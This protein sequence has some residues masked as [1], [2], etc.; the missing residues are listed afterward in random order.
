MADSA[1][2]ALPP[3]RRRMPETIAD[4]LLPP[5]CHL[6]SRTGIAESQALGPDLFSPRAPAAAR[7]L[8][9]GDIDDLRC[10]W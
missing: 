8:A 1:P 5:C 3:E 2:D 7:G 6:L 10:H 4:L 9:G